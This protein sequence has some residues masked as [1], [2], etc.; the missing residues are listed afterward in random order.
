MPLTIGDGPFVGCACTAGFFKGILLPMRSAQQG[1]SLLELMF[2]ITVMG[3]LLAIGIPSLGDF[4][5]RQ[6]IVAGGQDLQLDMA[7]ARQEAVTRGLPVSVC[8]SAD[9]LTC[10]AVGWAQQRI[11]FAD[12]NA[13]GVFDA[14]EEAIKYAAPLDSHI[15]AASPVN[16]VTFDATGA[17][18]AATTITIC[19][20]SFIG[21]VLSIRRTGHPVL[22][23]TAAACP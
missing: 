5:L 1:F 4:T 14:G 12:V 15:A 10:S 2:G 8:T 22:S 18:A 19:H 13:N 20:P 16:V 9:G 7:L 17:V 6:R 23:P 3:V 11:V 21:R